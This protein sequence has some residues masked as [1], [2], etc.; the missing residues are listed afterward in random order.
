MGAVEVF[1]NYTYQNINFLHSHPSQQ[2]HW[3]VSV[4][5]WSTR[6]LPNLYVLW[7]NFLYLLLYLLNVK[8]FKLLVQF[9]SNCVSHLECHQWPI[10]WIFPGK[11]INPAGTFLELVF[12]FFLLWFT[13]KIVSSVILN[14]QNGLSQFAFYFSYSFS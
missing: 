2:Q 6:C 1:W 12:L 14:H 3:P 4:Y 5:D 8:D 11:K 10:V 9:G 7:T 13:W